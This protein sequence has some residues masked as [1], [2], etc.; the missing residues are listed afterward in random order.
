MK[1]FL[2][3]LS[4]AFFGLTL[5][6][7]ADSTLLFSEVMYD[8]PGTDD[9][10]EYVKI[11]NTGADPVDQQH[12]Q[13]RYQSPAEERQYRLADHTCRRQFDSGRQCRHISLG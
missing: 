6:A 3:F 5:A 10:H 2:F 12:Y 11:E 4:L 1:K 7:Q 8:F 9:G 13:A